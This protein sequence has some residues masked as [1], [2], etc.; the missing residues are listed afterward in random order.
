MGLT[1]LIPVPS[2]LRRPESV[3]CLFLKKKEARR[4]RKMFSFKEL[5]FRSIMLDDDQHGTTNFL[6]GL[7]RDYGYPLV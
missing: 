5:Y 1:G 6:V 7:V 4:A 3:C 2:L